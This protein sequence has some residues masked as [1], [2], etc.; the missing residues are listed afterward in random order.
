M[1]LPAIAAAA[2]RGAAAAGRVAARVGQ[3]AVRAGRGAARI[4]R[5]AGR[6]ARR[7][8]RAER[9]KAE[10]KTAKRLLER[11]EAGEE[12]VE[13]A[14][15]EAKISPTDPDFILIFIFALLIDAFD[16]GL[17]ILSFFTLEIPQVIIKPIDAGAFIIISGWSFWR[18][19]NIAKS[20]MERKK[21]LLK[22]TKKLGKPGRAVTQRLTK[23]VAKKAVFR[24][25]GRGLLALIGESIPLFGMLPF[26]TI[27]VI[28]TLR[29][30]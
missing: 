15:E 9:R 19:G 23:I 12:E 10:K 24:I 29:E 11:P 14:G 22:L 17:E 8:E 30:K 21:Q 5:A 6:E 27:T 18:T 7:I 28:W 25:L 4:G 2:A 26:W 13:R 1:P 16:I 20:K 3:G